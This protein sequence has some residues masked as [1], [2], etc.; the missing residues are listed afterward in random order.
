MEKDFKQNQQNTASNQNWKTK[1]KE[2]KG[3]GAETYQSGQG[4]KG[5]TDPKQSSQ[6]G[7]K[8]GQLAGGSQQPG[9]QSRVQSNE[10]GAQDAQ[11]KTGRSSDVESADF[12]EQDTESA[13]DQSVDKDDSTKSFAADSQSRGN[14]GNDVKSQPSSRGSQNSRH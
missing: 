6:Q 9:Q 8:S 4:T 13:G 7:G 5:G 10:Q 1:D 3:A 11:M 2:T 14:K 12:K